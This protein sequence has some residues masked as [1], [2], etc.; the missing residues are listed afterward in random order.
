MVMAQHD[1]LMFLLLWVIKSMQVKVPHGQSFFFRVRIPFDLPVITSLRTHQVNNY[2]NRSLGA[3]SNMFL[4]GAFNGHNNVFKY[5]VDFW[6]LTMWSITLAVVVVVRSGILTTK[7]NNEFLLIPSVW[8]RVG[9]ARMRVFRRYFC[10]NLMKC[11]N[12]TVKWFRSIT[13]QLR[14]KVAYSGDGAA[15][16]VESVRWMAMC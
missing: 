5:F 8:P 11:F 14:S 15:E 4:L 7:I 3:M 2:S 9:Q 12:N 6:M 13:L 16:S 1:M 10:A